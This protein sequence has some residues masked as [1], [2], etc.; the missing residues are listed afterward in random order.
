M[1]GQGTL[2][3]KLYNLNSDNENKKTIDYRP[4]RIS[5]SAQKM[6]GV[7]MTKREK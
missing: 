4:L 3:L 6:L 2:N 5:T 7:G 1:R